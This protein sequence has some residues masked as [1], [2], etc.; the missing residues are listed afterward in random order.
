MQQNNGAE[1]EFTAHVACLSVKKN[2]E[3]IIIN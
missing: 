3:K 1:D 2:N